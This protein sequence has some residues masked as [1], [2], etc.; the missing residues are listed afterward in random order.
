MDEP[1]AGDAY[2][3][4][5]MGEVRTAAARRRDE[6]RFTSEDVEREVER[7]L[8]AA[9]DAAAVDPRVTARILHTLQDWNIEPAYWVHT[10][11]RGLAG[12]LLL[13]AKRAVRPL[14][15]LYTDHLFGRQAQLNL[16]L[17]QAVRDSLREVVRLELEL[18]ALKAGA[19]PGA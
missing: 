13:G 10:P 9:A 11:R 8:R 14:V 6:G 1:E 15:R 3:R 5:L 7:R 18:R 17:V 19:K 4:E 12:R 2:V 16:Y